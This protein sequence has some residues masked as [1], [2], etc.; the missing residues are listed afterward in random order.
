MVQFSY[1]ISLICK[2]VESSRCLVVPSCQGGKYYP[3]II[4]CTAVSAV[5]TSTLCCDNQRHQSP[6]SD[7]PRAHSTW[8][9]WD[10]VGGVGWWLPRSLI[11]ILSWG[12]CDLGNMHSLF[13]I[14]SMLDI[15]SM[16]ILYCYFQEYNIYTKELLVTSKIVVELWSQQII[17]CCHVGKRNSE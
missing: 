10:M 6:W 4:C 12:K 1:Y 2:Y 16:C 11:S 14:V 15:V 17:R 3:W 8:W 9:C 7:I 5:M 13:L